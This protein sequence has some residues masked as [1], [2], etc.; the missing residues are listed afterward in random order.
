[1]GLLIATYKIHPFAR[2]GLTA[3]GVQW[4]PEKDTAE[5]DVYVTVA[6][7]LITPPARKMP[8][9][10]EL[11]LTAAF[12][13]V[14]STTAD[15]TYQWQARNQGA[16]TWVNLH[17]PVTLVDVGTTYVEQTRSGYPAL[18]ANFNT[19]PFEIRL[20]LRCNEANQGRAK[21][22]NSTYVSIIY[23]V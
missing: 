13:A 8:A 1:M 16:T 20:Q 14:T 21:I 18:V 23:E 17:D 4:T 19:I 10:V 6:E 11:G 2:G 3:D 15:I 22:K 9:E 12:R 7:A 5:A